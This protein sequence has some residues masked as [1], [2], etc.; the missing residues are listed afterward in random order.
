M[1]K[2]AEK[3]KAIGVNVED[4]NGKFRAFG[5][6]VLD[7]GRVMDGSTKGDA[8]AVKELTSLFQRFGVTAFQGVYGQLKTGILDKSTGE[9]KRFGDALELMRDQLGAA[10]RE[11]R[12]RVLATFAGLSKRA[13]ATM[14]V[15][16]INIGESFEGLL[17]PLLKSVGGAMQTFTEMFMKVPLSAKKFAAG[18]FVAAAGLTAVFGASLMLVGAIVALTGATI[19]Y[20]ATLLPIIA[21]ATPVIALV[22]AMTAAFAVFG[23]GLAFMVYENIGGTAKSLQDT[24][25]R[26][27]LIFQSVIGFLTEGKLSGSLAEEFMKSDAATQDFIVRATLFFEKIEAFMGGFYE[28]MKTYM[29]LARPSI[30]ALGNA[31]LGLGVALGFVDSKYLAA[32]ETMSR[33]DFEKA[34]ATTARVF[35]AAFMTITWA[36]TMASTSS[37]RRLRCWTGWQ[38]ASWVGSSSVRQ[39]TPGWA[40]GLSQSVRGAASSAVVMELT[41]LLGPHRGTGYRLS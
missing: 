29:E 6:V 2:N 12:A 38:A 10:A 21:I 15:L 26:W 9:V 31:I 13:E 41:Y 7:V 5:D 18:L 28:G 25:D 24:F 27:K 35:T 22:A 20:S 19:A 37:T 16:K 1:A 8:A 39:R 30:D 33:G 17:G 14:E 34:G 4:A 11:D 32:S 3:F 40:A 23:S 36:I